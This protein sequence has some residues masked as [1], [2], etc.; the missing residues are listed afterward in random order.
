MSAIESDTY[1]DGGGVYADQPLGNGAIVRF[2]V[3]PEDRQRDVT[4]QIRDGLLRVAG[5]NRPVAFWSPVPNVVTVTTNR[6]V[7]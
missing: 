3:D 5:V 2:V 7:T 4:V 6:S 1:I